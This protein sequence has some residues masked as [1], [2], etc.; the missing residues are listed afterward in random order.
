MNA[1]QF[2]PRSILITGAS[3]GIGRALAL[4][5]AAP[6]VFLALSGRNEER[7]E[8]VA[9]ACRA[10]GARTDIAIL[11]VAHRAE[12]EDWIADVEKQAPLDLVIANAGIS[13]GTGGVMNGNRKTRRGRF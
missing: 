11:D 12:M 3:S 6:D 10:K 9:D 13:G 5:Y 8:E 2:L 7:L 1:A 4:H